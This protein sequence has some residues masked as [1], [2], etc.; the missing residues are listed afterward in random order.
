MRR[1]TADI[2]IFSVSALDLFASALGAFLLIV[3]ILF[4]YY[5]RGGVDVSMEELEDLVQRRR[6]AA[7]TMNTEM[8]KIRALK[9]EIKYLDKQYMSTEENMSEIEEKIKELLKAASEVEIPDPPPIPKPEPIPEPIPPQSVAQGSE[10]S[11]LGLAT[12]KKKVVILVDMSGSMQNYTRIATNALNEIVGQMKPD[13]DFSIIGYRG[14]SKFEYYPPSGGTL[15]ATQGN[16][17]GARSFISA[18]PRKFRG[19]TPTQAGLLQALRLR[20]EAIILLSDGEPTDGLPGSIIAGIT[21]QNRGQAEIHTVA[22]GD[23][24]KDRKLTLF[25]QQLAENNRG[26]FVGITR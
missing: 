13:Y 21:R 1:R 23:Y 18:L 20:P 19:G 17:S 4:P 24:T 12:N 25:L 6:E 3:L 16:I 22:I 8:S 7:S 14:S 2:S 10:F 15:K 11:I 5:Q 9:A 26:E